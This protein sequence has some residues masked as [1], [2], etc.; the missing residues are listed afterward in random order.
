MPDRISMAEIPSSQESSIRSRVL[1]TLVLF[2]HANRLVSVLPHMPPEAIAFELCRLWFDHIYTPGM[3]YMDGL[4]GDPD[5]DA[6]E[7]FRHAFSEEETSWLERF[8]RF[9][10]LRI[11]RLSDE[12]KAQGVFP[13]NDTWNGIMR[14][15]GNLV[16]LMDTDEKRRTRRI[17]GVMR[18][19]IPGIGNK[20]AVE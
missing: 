11:D 8:H 18:E 20:G 16:D 17:S 3:R 5:P 1:D 15:A 9:L 4:K 13:A 6:A 14:D 12:Q 7:A 2:R 19:L 10:E